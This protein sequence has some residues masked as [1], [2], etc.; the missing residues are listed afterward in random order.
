MSV[1]AL[2]LVASSARRPRGKQLEKR[3]SSGMRKTRLS[4]AVAVLLTIGL[5]PVFAGG[6]K[7]LAYGGGA[8][9]ETW[10]IGISSNCN[11]PSQCGDQLGGFWGWVEFDRSGSNTWGDA[12]LA[13]CGHTVGGGGP[14]S[15]GAGHFSVEVERW[16]IAAGSAGPQTFF[17]TSGT[18]TFTGHGT[19]VTD[20]LR[21]DFGVLITP[22]HLLDT[23]IP[24]VPGHY[25]TTDI[26]GSQ[27]PGLAF[28]IQVAYR[29]AK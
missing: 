16:V 28:L 8:S 10:Q 26:F 3:G 20:S 2:T 12:E 29:P 22:T 14:G 21:D 6:G 15:A 19:P 27:A 24:A 18:Q 25:G 5:L 17:V 13:G 11:N 4:L 9:H 7:A 1:S 23:G